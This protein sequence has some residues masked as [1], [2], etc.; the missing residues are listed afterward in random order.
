MSTSKPGFVTED[1]VRNLSPRDAALACADGAILLDVR[2]EY[3]NQQKRISVP[4]LIQIPLSRL[5][6]VLNIVPKDRPIIVADSSGLRSKEAVVLLKEKGY[7]R[8]FNLAGG[9]VEW[10]RDGMPLVEDISQKLSG[11]CACQLRPRGKGEPR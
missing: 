7:D 2:E 5:A 1:G 4:S 6:D 9:L 11:S 10:E 8:V 3:I